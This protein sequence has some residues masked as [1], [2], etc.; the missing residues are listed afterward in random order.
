MA[1]DGIAHLVLVILAEVAHVDRVTDLRLAGESLGPELGHGRVPDPLE[2]ATDQGGI[3]GGG[4]E[5][6]RPNLVDAQIGDQ[7]SRARR[8]CRGR[9]G[10]ALA[11]CAM[12]GQ[13][14]RRGVVRRPE[15]KQREAA[16]VVTALDRDHLD[17]RGHVFVGDLNDRGG[18]VN[19][20]HPRLLSERFERGGGLGGVEGHPATEEIPRVDPTE[21]KVGIG[22][23]RLHAALAVAGR[24]R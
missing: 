7:H 20:A 12:P 1:S 5:R 9:A 22:H 19:H 18:E 14:L 21:D 8:H 16:R 17:R 4:L 2:L 13:L 23:G 3:D 11:G 10:P 15:G 6:L 24:S